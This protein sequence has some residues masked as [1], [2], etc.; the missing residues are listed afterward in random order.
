MVKSQFLS[1]NVS[2][3]YNNGEAKSLNES[4][5]TG[6]KHL[7]RVYEA[8]DSQ[9]KCFSSNS[10]WFPP[11]DQPNCGIINQTSNNPTPC[12]GLAT[13][14]ERQGDKHRNN[15]LLIVCRKPS[16]KDSLY[17]QYH[18]LRNGVALTFLL[19][20]ADLRCENPPRVQ[21]CPAMLFRLQRI[22]FVTATFSLRFT[23]RKTPVSLAVWILSSFLQDCIHK[24]PMGVVLSFFSISLTF[25]ASSG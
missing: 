4:K 2:F 24:F 6:W 18:W 21:P 12:V 5:S 22:R 17:Y 8:Y 10:H 11:F 13:F 23:L 19:A 3:K 20:L 9:R 7:W 14:P 1:D 15:Q 16:S 25:F